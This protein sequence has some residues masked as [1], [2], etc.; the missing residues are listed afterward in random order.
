[1]KL[2][3]IITFGGLAAI[4][5]TAFCIGCTDNE[6]EGVVPELQA[7]VITYE[8]AVCE[9]IVGEEDSGTVATATASNGADISYS[10]T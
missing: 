8:N 1:M 2:K 6:N 3:K 5:A 9:S 10:L 7:G 4:M